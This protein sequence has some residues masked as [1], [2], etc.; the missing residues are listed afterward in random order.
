[1]SPAKKEGTR[2]RTRKS[3]RQK[4]AEPKQEAAKQAEVQLKIERLNKPKNTA[5]IILGGFLQRRESNDIL[6]TVTSLQE[7]GYVKVIFDLADVKYAN[8]SAIGVFVNCASSLKAAGGHAVL[9]AMR[10]N[11]RK[12]FDTL[13]LAGLFIIA[14][15]KEEAVKAVS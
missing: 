5:L 10:P 4:V 14:S 7:E 12:V 2:K 13:G 6:R 8:S 3:A 15:T 11:I 9:L 1:M